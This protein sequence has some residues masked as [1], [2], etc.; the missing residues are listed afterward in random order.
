[1]QLHRIA[2]GP[3]FANRLDLIPTGIEE[4]GEEGAVIEG[5]LGDGF[6][7]RCLEILPVSSSPGLSQSS[8]KP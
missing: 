8:D 5:K 7:K 4:H 6:L 1:V 3:C 2:D